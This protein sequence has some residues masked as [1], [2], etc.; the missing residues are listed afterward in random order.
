MEA[1]MTLKPTTGKDTLRFEKVL[2][3]ILGLCLVALVGIQV[4]RLF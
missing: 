4:F 3:L 1:T 2:L